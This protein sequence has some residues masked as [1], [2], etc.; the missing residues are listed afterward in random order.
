MGRLKRAP[1]TLSMIAELHAELDEL[2][3]PMPED[4]T[5]EGDRLDRFNELIARIGLQQ[6]IE[7]D[8]PDQVEAFERMVK[9]LTA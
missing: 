2:L 8:R 5:L 3:A 6:A 9:Q 7:D 4:G 1:S